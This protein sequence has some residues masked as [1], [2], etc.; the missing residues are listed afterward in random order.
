[1]EGFKSHF[2]KL[3]S[4]LRRRGSRPEEAEDLV[5]E[6]YVR[7]LT[8]I[9]RGEKILEPE[10]FL[11]RTVLNLAVD[12]SRHERALVAEAQSIE[13]F[14]LIDHRLG[15]EEETATEQ[16]LSN[17]QRTLDWTV[18]EKTRNAFFLHCLEGMTYDEVGMQLNL[19]GRSVERHIAKAIAVLSLEK[20]PLP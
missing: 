5:Q 8:Y 12:H 19:S 9:D 1:M 11:A 18:G 10:A 14:S 7:L 13:E 20:Q 6:A 3:C 4:L 2:S 16:I 15:P 17:A